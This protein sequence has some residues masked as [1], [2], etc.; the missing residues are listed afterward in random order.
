MA[1]RRIIEAGD[2]SLLKKSRP[3][4]E[5]NGRL[6]QLLDDMAETLT[7]ARG[8]GLAA[9]QVG[10]LRRVCLVLDEDSEEYIELINPEIIFQDGEQTG[11]EGC[12]S[13]PGKWGVVTRPDHVRVRAQDREGNWFEVE[14][15]GLTARAFCHEIEHLDGHLFSEYV[16]HFLT[17]EELSE[18]LEAEGAEEDENVEPEA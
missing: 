17:D 12:L 8:A 7:D 15:E 18:Y 6:R 9:P 16:D 3:V 1:L 2:D 13:L 4:T 11:L 10:V 5:F 14:G